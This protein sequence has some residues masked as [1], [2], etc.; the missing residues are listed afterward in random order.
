VKQLIDDFARY[1]YLP[2]LAGPDVLIQAIREGVALLTWRVDTFGYAESYDEAA[3]RYRGLRCG[4]RINVLPDSTGLLVKPDVAA[5]Q[6]DAGMTPPPGA[7]T[8]STGPGNGKPI[9]NP[10]SP[11][12]GPAA[13][14][15]PQLK[16]FHGSVRL[17]SARVGRD[18]GRIAEEV[19]AHLLGQI[20][21]ELA[22]TLEIEAHLPNGVTDQLVRSVTE[23]SRTLRFDSHGFEPE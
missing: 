1:L 22:V 11:D 4:Q 5:E 14:V 10:A 15:V 13:P 20:G 3:L 19:I 12:S 2:R 17:D 9:L 23:N 7:P 8:S 18:A 6:L 16:R 21:A